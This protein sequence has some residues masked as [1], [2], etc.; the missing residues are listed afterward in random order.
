MLTRLTEALRTRPTFGRETSHGRAVTEAGFAT[1]YRE[2]ELVLRADMPAGVG[3]SGTGPTPGV[4]GRAAVATCTALAVRIA[5]E[6]W[7][8]PYSNH[9]RP[10]HKRSFAEGFT[11][12]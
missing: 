3:G 4:Y 2:G 6:R 8:V 5:A 11:I 7:G 10:F 9:P 1:I 12:L